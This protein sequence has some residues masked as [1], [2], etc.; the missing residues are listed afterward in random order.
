[1]RQIALIALIKNMVSLDCQFIIATHSPILLATPNSTIYEFDN[2]AIRETAYDDL[3]H[4]TLTRSFLSDP[5]A[6]LRRL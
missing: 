1:M 2:G 5:E 3:E 4:V 6:F